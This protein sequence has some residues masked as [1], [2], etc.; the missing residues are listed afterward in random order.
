[1]E[2]LVKLNEN[3]LRKIVRQSLNELNYNTIEKASY[4]GPDFQ[5]VEDAIITIEDALN[6]YGFSMNNGSRYSNKQYNEA[7]RGI[8]AIRNY[9]DRKQKQ[10]LNFRGTMD[11]MRDKAEKEFN[12]AI[13]RMY[14]GVK[15]IYNE[16]SDEEIQKV[17]ETLPTDTQ[18]TL[19]YIL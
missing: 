18:E 7:V 2:Q 8:E 9:F 14:P 5:N 6:N 3:D 10:Q 16:L 12:N 19:K 4:K 13:Q 1:M 17:L 15:N 11:D